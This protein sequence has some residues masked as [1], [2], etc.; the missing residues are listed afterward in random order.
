MDGVFYTADINNR[1]AIENLEITVTGNL[2]QAL[3]STFTDSNGFGNVSINETLEYYTV[4]YSKV[5]YHTQYI[6]YTWTVD[7][8]ESVYMYPISDDGI[9]RLRFND[10]TFNTRE[11]CIFYDLNDR[12]E[13][14]YGANETVQLLVNQNY[15]VNPKLVTMDLLSSEDSVKN[16]F[17]MYIMLVS[18]V[19]V[20]AF[21]FGLILYLLYSMM[22]GKR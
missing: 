12:L 19:M 1:Q 5:G 13:G 16:N 6:N 20:A 4:Q 9:V 14:C 22:R 8:S 3:N 18:A 10:L 21:P 7:F 15:T 17:L 2:S 11:F